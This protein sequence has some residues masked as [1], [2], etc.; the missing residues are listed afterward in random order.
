MTQYT[1]SGMRAR[2]EYRA[3]SAYRICRQAN[4]DRRG[5]VLPPVLLIRKTKPYSGGETPPLH[6]ALPTSFLNFAR[7]AYRICRQ[8]NISS[9]HS[10]HIDRRQANIDRRGGVSPPVLLI[11]KTRLY[12]GGET[13]PLHFALLSETFPVA[14]KSISQS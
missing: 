13:P 5:G 11:R 3:R 6:F 7:S 1:A 12:S 9:E 8:A 14:P 4:I 10:S 2:S